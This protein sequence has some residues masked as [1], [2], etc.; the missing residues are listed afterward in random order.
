MKSHINSMW[1]KGFQSQNVNKKSKKVITYVYRKYKPHMHMHWFFH[2]V[3]YDIEVKNSVSSNKRIFLSDIQVVS[4][5]SWLSVN[6]FVFSLDRKIH[7]NW[8][9]SWNRLG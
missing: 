9:L 2:K 8:I 6:S 1:V 4:I 3:L 7:F 5:M